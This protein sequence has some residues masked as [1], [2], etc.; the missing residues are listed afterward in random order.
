[1]V[2]PSCALWLFFY[3]GRL[4]GDMVSNLA[5]WMFSSLLSVTHEDVK[6]VVLYLCPG[7]LTGLAI[8][9]F[10]YLL[11]LCDLHSNYFLGNC[12]RCKYVGIQYKTLE[13]LGTSWVDIFSCIPWLRLLHFRQIIRSRRW[14]RYTLHY[15]TCVACLTVTTSPAS[16]VSC[17]TS[18]QTFPLKFLC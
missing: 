14:C 10:P 2:H 12:L 18:L 11:C 1:M 8:L 15:W 6:K 3:H 4:L 16:S 7:Y 17:Q 5:I 13:D 9:F